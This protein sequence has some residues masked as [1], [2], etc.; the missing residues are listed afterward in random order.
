MAS[1]HYRQRT[2]FILLVVAVGIVG[3]T[4]L[5]AVPHPQLPGLTYGTLFLA[6]SGIYMSLVPTLCFVGKR[7]LQAA[8]KKEEVFD[9]ITNGFWITIQQTTLLLRLKEPLAWLISFAWEISV[10]LQ[11]PTSFSHKKHLT[12][13]QATNSSWESTV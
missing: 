13:G 5:L 9:I 12:I 6:T 10:V 11:A 4:A 3:F 1:D 8:I 2:P 7:T